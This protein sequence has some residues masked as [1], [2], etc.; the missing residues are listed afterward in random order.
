MIFAHYA[1]LRLGD[2]ILKKLCFLI[3]TVLLLGTFSTLRLSSSS[4]TAVS[5]APSRLDVLPGQV[6]TVDVIATNVSDLFNWQVAVEYDAKII[7][8][9]AAW[10]P[11]DNVFAGQSQV[12]VPPVLNDPTNNGHNYTLFGNTLISGSVM[13]EQ[14]F[15]CKLNFTT[16]A[17]GQTTIRMGTAADPIVIFKTNPF[18]LVNYTRETYLLDSNMAEMQFISENS[19]VLSGPQT[20]LTILSSSGG[21]TDP[22]L[23]NHT[24]AYGTNVSVT[25]IP[26]SSYVFDHWLLNTS[27]ERANPLNVI[28]NFNYTLQPIFTRKNYTLTMLESTNG[29][30]N[31]SP[32]EHTY[33]AGE[34]VQVIA[35]ANT[36]YRFDRWVKDGS[37]V[38][39]DNPLT[40]VMNGNYTLSAVFSVVSYV[41]TVYIRAD[42]SVDPSDA[43]VSTVDNVTYTLTENMDSMIVVQRSN[44]V[45]DGDR[46]A[47]QGSGTGEGVSLFGVSN[48]TVKNMSI[49]GFGCGMY[50][51]WASQNVVAGNN[52]TG[53]NWLGLRL[54]FSSN[55]SMC[56]NNIL[57]NKDDGIRFEFSSNY[58][59]IVGNN[60]MANNWLG[61][62][63]DSSCTNSF[64]HNNLA[65]N[66]NQV[67]VDPHGL[68]P[69]N[70]WDNGMEG[71]YWSNYIGADSNYDGVGDTPYTIDSNNTDHYPLVGVFSSFR[72]SSAYSVETLSNS[73]IKSFTCFAAEKRIS[74][75]VDGQS[76][77]VGFCKMIIP[78]DLV[79]PVY[80]QVLIDNG[81]TPLLHLNR[82]LY[83]N[84]T[85]RWIYFAYSHSAH[86]VV[87]QEDTTPPKILVLSPENRTYASRVI[88]LAFSVNETVSWSG[89]SLDGSDNLT[90]TGNATLQGLTDGEHSLVVFANDTVGNMGSSD[91]VF[92]KVD[93]IPPSVSA[94]SPENKTY[95]T[96]NVTLTFTTN[97]SAHWMGYSLD[98]GAN[99][100]V[101]QNTTLTGLADGPHSLII[102]A[103]DAAGNTGGSGVIFFLVDSTPP[104]IVSTVQY[105]PITDVLPGNNVDINATI[106]D[107]VTAVKSVILTYAFVAINGAGNGS[108]V[109]TEV[110][111]NV[112]T[113]TIPRLPYGTNVTYTI[114][115]S[116][117]AGNTVT[118]EQL[119]YEYRYT[120]VPEYPI[121]FILSLWMAGLLAMALKAKKKTVSRRCSARTLDTLS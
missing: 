73:T 3:I 112:W 8:C 97:E 74:F 118:T 12:P 34:T 69:H 90:L 56:D 119:G 92:F 96:R 26:D 57:A 80:L 54:Y 9:I 4:G 31:I 25:G 37:D 35:T 59:N 100:T 104:N 44:V 30:T 18:S 22:V 111:S 108:I 110:M 91:P 66:A 58:N 87:I 89:F 113:A 76:N 17:N 49:R 103:S 1:L 84:L 107:N 62:Y 5:L 109:M 72:P 78:H 98:G 46:H 6:F 61:I 51:F 24:Y 117:N 52:I 77:T 43:V 93:T 33:Y 60:I 15:L 13:V 55:N 19:E 21:T 2:S 99:V 71:N 41:G 68:P 95:A 40:L 82:N 83:D 50:L 14:G 27:D 7:N 65:N 102:Y 106:I 16:L 70:V 85:H 116:D 115:A 32:G 121:M 79:N 20:M 48:V 10:I 114:V 86:T 63:L 75:G 88:P 120:V 29:T 67:S 94:L 39:S 42:G 53:N 28:M 36:G 45:L 47:L 101:T 23:G 105:P 38:G 11:T 64:Y 81:N